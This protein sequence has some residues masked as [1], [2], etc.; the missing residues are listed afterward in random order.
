MPLQWEEKSFLPEVREDLWVLAGRII[1]VQVPVGI[2]I[3][4]I[5]LLNAG[6]VNRYYT[7]HEA[8]NKN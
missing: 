7:K 8:P 5:Y 3:E 2:C 4:R 1:D 6:S